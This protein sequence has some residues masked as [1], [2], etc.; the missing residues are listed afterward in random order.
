MDPDLI[1]V[2]SVFLICAVLVT[3][4]GVTHQV[5]KYRSGRNASDSRQEGVGLSE[6]SGVIRS[7]VAEANQPLLERVEDLEEEIRMLHTALGHGE[8]ERLPASEQPRGL[9]PSGERRAGEDL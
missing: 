6:L 7:A 3:I 5:M 4:L 2:A 8:R 1:I 9:P